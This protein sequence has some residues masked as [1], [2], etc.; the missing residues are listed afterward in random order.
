MEKLKYKVIKSEKQ[1]DEY[2]NILANLVAAPNITQGLTDEI[3]LLTLLIETWD[4]SHSSFKDANP[5]EVLQSLMEENNIKATELAAMLGISKS[6]VSDM[7]HYRRG[8]SKE[9]I[10]KL[11]ERFKVSQELFN[12]PYKLVSPLNTQLQKAPVT[13]TAKKLK[14]V[15]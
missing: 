4:Q 11:A 14:A 7:L 13:D 10:R 2:C 1:Y 12:R 8:L 15:R 5:I 3:E 9:N 6:L